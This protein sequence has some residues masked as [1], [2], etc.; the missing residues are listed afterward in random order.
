LLNK[1]TKRKEKKEMDG[2]TLLATPTIKANNGNGFFGID[3][4]EC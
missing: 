3:I 2:K 1:K 4:I